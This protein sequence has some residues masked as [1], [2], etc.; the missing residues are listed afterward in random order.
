MDRTYT[1][2]KDAGSGRRYKMYPSLEWFHKKTRL[3]M[4]EELIK[5]ILFKDLISFLSNVVGMDTSENL[6]GSTRVTT[7]DE[8][9]FLQPHCAHEIDFHKYNY[10]LSFDNAEWIDE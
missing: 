3:L 5:S 4:G 7:K 8:Q 6:Y 1:I 9:Y 2:Y 10:A